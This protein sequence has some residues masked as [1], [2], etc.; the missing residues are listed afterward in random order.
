MNFA[1]AYRTT[2]PHD[3]REGVPPDAPAAGGRPPVFGL[4]RTPLVCYALGR[5]RTRD[6]QAQHRRGRVFR[7]GERGADAQACRRAESR[8]RLDG[9]QRAEEAALD[10]L[11]QMRNGPPG[12]RLP[13]RAGRPLLLLRWHVPRRG[14]A[15]EDRRAGGWRDREIDVADLRKALTDADSRRPRGGAARWRTAVRRTGTGPGPR[16]RRSAWDNRGRP[17]PLPW[18]APPRAPTTGSGWPRSRRS[19]P[20]ARRAGRSGH[21]PAAR[22]RRRRRAPS[23]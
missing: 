8:A 4:A 20:A 17:P 21:N 23:P 6:R 9:A 3:W 15:G 12:D 22:A 18:P 19:R 10:A 14:R 5:R 7:A 1:S 11:S 16:S 13:R 2:V